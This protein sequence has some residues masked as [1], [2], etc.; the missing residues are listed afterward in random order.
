MYMYI[1]NIIFYSY[2]KYDMKAN[3]LIIEVTIK[4]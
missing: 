4:N 3:K 2:I 1:Y